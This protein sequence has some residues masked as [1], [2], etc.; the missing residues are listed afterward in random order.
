MIRIVT[1][2]NLNVF[3]GKVVVYSTNLVNFAY[4]KSI[5]GLDKTMTYGF[6]SRY[7][8]KWSHNEWGYNVERLIYSIDVDSDCGIVNNILKSIGGRMSMRLADDG[9]ITIIRDL[10][11]T[12][13]AKFETIHS[14]EL[15]LAMLTTDSFSSYYSYSDSE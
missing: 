9:E 3:S 5:T 7:P 14:R 6:V 12:G 4:E 10:I 13:V 8:Y 1:W 11:K 2:E 15:M